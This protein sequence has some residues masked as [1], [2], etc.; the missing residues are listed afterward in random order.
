MEFNWASE[1]GSTKFFGFEALARDKISK[2]GA[3]LKLE[4]WLKTQSW[5]GNFSILN[6]LAS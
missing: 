1:N 6:N 2:L 4:I 3:Y 5:N